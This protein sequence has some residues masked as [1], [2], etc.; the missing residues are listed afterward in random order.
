[1]VALSWAE[2]LDKGQMDKGQINKGR[3]T[4]ITYPDFCKVFNIVVHKIFVSEMER[5]GFDGW[6]MWCIRNWLDGTL[7]ELWSTVRC[8]DGD[9]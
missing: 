6:T 9:Q 1:M 3:V 5:H 4:D 8:L 7:K 2:R